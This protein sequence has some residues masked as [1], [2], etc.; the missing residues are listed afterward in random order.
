MLTNEKYYYINKKVNVVF[1]LPN[2]FPEDIN[3]RVIC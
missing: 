2:Y 1:I 3:T